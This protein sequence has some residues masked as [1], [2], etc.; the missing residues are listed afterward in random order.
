MYVEL[1]VV[2][3]HVP[4]PHH[5]D[6]F[7]L[8]DI[9]AR[10]ID[11]PVSIVAPFIEDFP[12]AL[13]A[14]LAPPASSVSSTIR[15][16]IP[17]KQGYLVR[18]RCFQQRFVL[19]Q[20][21]GRL[22][23]FTVFDQPTRLISKEDLKYADMTD[24]LESAIFA[25]VTNANENPPT[26]TTRDRAAVEDIY[27]RT[28]FEW[29]SHAPSGRKLLALLHGRDNA[30]D[31]AWIHASASALGMDIV[32]LDRPGHWLQHD[33]YRHLYREFIPIDMTIDD[34]FHMRISTALAAFGHIDG[35]YTVSDRCH[36]PMARAAATLDLPAEPICCFRSAL[37]KHHIRYLDSG[38]TRSFIQ[39][40]TVTEMQAAIDD[41]S[42]IPRY[43]VIVKPTMG[44]GSEFVYRS[45]DYEE[46]CAA[47]HKARRGF[48]G[49]VLIE[50][51]LDGPEFDA[52]VI[53]CDGQVVYFDV[54]DDFPSAGDDECIGTNGDFV[55]TLMVW[56]SALPRDEY[57]LIRAKTQRLVHDLGFRNGVFNIEGRMQQ[58]RVSYTLRD[59]NL[60]LHH[61]QNPVERCVTPRCTILEVNTRALA[62]NGAIAINAAHGV[63]VTDA[64]ILLAVGDGAR[65]KALSQYFMPKSGMPNNAR[66]WSQLAFF[67][68]QSHGVCSTDDACGEYL[69]RNPQMESKTISSA[70]YYK[71]GDTIIPS[72]DG[73]TAPCAWF[74]LGTHGLRG[75]VCMLDNAMREGFSIPVTKL[76]QYTATDEVK[77]HGERVGRTSRND[78]C[79]ANQLAQE[80]SRAEKM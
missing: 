42:F 29:L 13:V 54:G 55:E 39:V 70:C 79:I 24:L 1:Q 62:Y 34:S 53:L 26:T 9:E 73:I 19:C 38:D 27:A 71:A 30:Y 33:Q 40:K 31:F 18:S 63:N 37:D 20:H 4:P 8:L 7:A 77:R 66:M 11:K 50:P 59:G 12:P 75:E 43:P 45:G 51:Y 28:N 14:L 23:D 21:L 67:K 2:K 32:V 35:L 74:A 47:V 80:L 49:K 58:S 56:P 25:F 65:T 60:D 68:P 15:L 17:T 48:S 64:Q 16:A 6:S 46:L 61:V 72:T 41:E 76:E 10:A 52:T 3:Q 69:A 44:W 36:I 78:S 5:N 57:A 22:V